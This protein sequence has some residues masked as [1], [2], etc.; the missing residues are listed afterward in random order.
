MSLEVYMACFDFHIEIL[1]TMSSYAQHAEEGASGETDSKFI[2]R[3]HKCRVLRWYR[4]Q[5][6]YP[7]SHESPLEEKIPRLVAP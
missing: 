6:L 4:H 2:I 1:M 3:Q 5:P 7:R